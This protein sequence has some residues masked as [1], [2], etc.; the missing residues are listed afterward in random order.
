MTESETPDSP[1]PTAEF[2]DEPIA[3]P[4]AAGQP[5]FTPRQVY[6]G[7]MLGGPLAAVYFIWRNFKTLGDGRRGRLTLVLGGIMSALLVLILPFLPERT[8]NLVI[9]LAYSWLAFYLVKAFQKSKE[10]IAAS[11]IFTFQSNWKVAGVTLLSLVL[12]LPPTF[13]VV[14]W[15]EQRKLPPHQAIAAKDL[16]RTVEALESR[17]KEKTF[18]AFALTPPDAK[19]GEDAVNLEYRI[20]EGKPTLLWALL[21]KR[22]IADRDQITRFAQERGIT[23]VEIQDGKT[24]LLFSQ[25]AGIKELGEQILREFYRLT[26]ET[27]IEAFEGQG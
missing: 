10:Q 15:A 4:R 7:S 6:A 1:Q 2:P 8:P 25:D 21:S 5:L 27:R 18:V 14:I 12:L 11:G 23:L 17:R 26:P 3:P 22:N 19:A 13:G 16:R 24:R 20:V 9:P